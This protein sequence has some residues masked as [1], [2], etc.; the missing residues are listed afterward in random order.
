M[1]LIERFYFLVPALIFFVLYFQTIFYG[2]AWGDDIMVINP[3]ARDFS[4]MLK[5]FYDLNF[6]VADH[7][8]PFFYLQCFFVNFLFG[9]NA[10]PLGFHL[11]Q[12]LSVGI[13]CIVAVLVFYEITKNKIISTLIVLF[14]VVHPINMQQQTRLLVG[15]NNMAF[16]LC[17]VF[18]LC[19]LKAR[20]IKNSTQRIG[21]QTIGSLCFLCS[22]LT[23]EWF[24]HFPL[25]LCLLY[26][27]FEGKAIFKHRIMSLFLPIALTYGVYFGLRFLVTQGALIES[28]GELIRWTELG[29]I[30]D[31]LFRAIWLS[32]QLLVHYLKLF[33]FPFGLIDSAAEWYFVGDSVFSLYSLFCQLVILGLIVSSVFLYKRFPLYSIGIFWFLISYL[34]VIQII[35]LFSIAALRY[36][37]IPT[38][39]LLLA[40][41]SL[42]MYLSIWRKK[43]F[44]IGVLCLLCFFSWRTVHYLPSSKD[45]LHQ[46]IYCAKEA[47]LWNKQ[48][49]IARAIEHANKHKRI[50]ELPGWLDEQAFAEAITKWIDTNLVINPGLSVQFGPMQMPYN[51][52]AF[53]GAFRFLYESGQEKAL[54]QAFQSAIVVKNDWFGW[55]EV[56]RFLGSV[57][58]WKY[59]W[60]C[61]SKSI[62]L[63]PYSKHPYNLKFI[64]I[65]FYSHKFNEAESLIKNFIS[66]RSNSSY[67][68]FIA[69]LFYKRIDK[70]NL[71]ISYFKQ[72]LFSDK[73]LSVQYSD[74]YVQGANFFIEKNMPIE[75][76]KTLKI[77]LSFDPFNEEAQAILQK[78]T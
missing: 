68:Y 44:L 31:I 65:S 36:C 34:L 46:Y 72:A 63:N 49:Y 75:A 56:A 1:K 10:F 16:L 73:T 61:I 53:R 37:Y 23:A 4:L 41:F 35:P 32:P 20:T 54:K 30:N 24:I 27:Y 7:Y 40:I 47:P 3:Q 5:S 13:L 14:W 57:Q 52:Y 69:A 50:L 55:Y 58:E 26:F 70:P 17:F 74:F 2:S 76:K 15:P 38:V 45:L 51:F 48:I 78:L 21:L 29:S 25:L 59:A 66:L 12:Y 67:P 42:C 9:E 62:E 43:I 60:Q 19:Y 11:Y 39:G 6:M 77:L 22:M 33:F 28:A 18:F 71:A 64:E 8:I